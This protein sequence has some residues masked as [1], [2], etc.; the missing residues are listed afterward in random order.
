MRVFP[1]MAG[2]CAGVLAARAVAA[3]DLPAE[4]QR[5]VSQYKAVMNAPPQGVPSRNV[6]AAPLM[7]NGSLGVVI[8]VEPQTWPLQFWTCKS[9]FCKLR[10]D[11]RKGGP[12]PFGGLDL[13]MPALKGGSWHTEQDVYSAITTGKFT[14]GTHSVSMRTFVAATE[15]LLI[16][17]LTNDGKE[18]VDGGCKMWALPGRGS[19]EQ[20]LDKIDDAKGKFL[21]A[22]KAYLSGKEGGTHPAEIPTSAACA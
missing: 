12:R 19:K 6:V 3:E 17:E 13:G 7:G 2:L 21:C 11:H 9:S 20:I 8:S 16:I 14:K 15:D 1:L 5:I 10:H 22:T 4:A 18:P